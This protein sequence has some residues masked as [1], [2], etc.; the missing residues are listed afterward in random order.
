MQKAGEPENDA[1]FLKHIA[2]Q[3]NCSCYSYPSNTQFTLQRLDRSNRS[4]TLANHSVNRTVPYR[5]VLDRF[6]CVLWNVCERFHKRFQD[7]NVS[8]DVP[9][10]VSKDVP[11]N[12]LLNV[13]AT[14]AS[15]LVCSMARIFYII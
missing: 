7:E 4:G 15:F 3:L 13:V 10:N 1:G 11:K 9:K 5:T 12:V 2:S 14:E 6:R 8:K